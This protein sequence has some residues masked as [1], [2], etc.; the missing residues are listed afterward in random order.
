MTEMKAISMHLRELK[1]LTM[2][3]KKQ[4]PKNLK[5]FKNITKPYLIAEIGINHNGDIDIAKRLIDAAF[6]SMG[7]SKISKKEP[8]CLC[9]RRSKKSKELHLG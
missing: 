5:M 2:I 7:L 9:S 3:I 6:A 1:I 4:R 8:R